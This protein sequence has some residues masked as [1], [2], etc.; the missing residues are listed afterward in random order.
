[1]QH[2]CEILHKYVWTK[3]IIRIIAALGLAAWIVLVDIVVEI[4]LS[5]DLAALAVQGG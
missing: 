1:M 3:I 4:F 2:F 5:H